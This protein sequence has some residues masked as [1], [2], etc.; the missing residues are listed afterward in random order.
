MSIYSEHLLLVCCKQNDP[1][2]ADTERGDG[3]MGCGRVA[4]CILLP[5]LAVLDKGC[6]NI[7]LVAV[8]TLFGWVPGAIAALIIC[9]AA[10]K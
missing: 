2:L 8:L 6:G 9:N 7:V 1:E 10:K 3:N 4:L 5:P